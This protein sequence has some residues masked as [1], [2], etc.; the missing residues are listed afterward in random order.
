MWKWR[1]CSRNVKNIHPQPN[2][3]HVPE[4]T[5][6]TAWASHLNTMSRFAANE[7][8][9]AELTQHELLVLWTDYFTPEHIEASPDLHE[10]VWNATKRCSKTKQNVDVSA[11]EDLMAAIETIH[12]M[13]SESKNRD[14]AWIPAVG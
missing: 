6:D 8:E 14:V 4:G 5:D 13:F 11:A 2:D 12:K 9:K 10:T 7:E 1:Q 3:L